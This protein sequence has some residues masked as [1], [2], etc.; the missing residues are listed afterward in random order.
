MK[1]RSILVIL[2]NKICYKIILIMYFA[3]WSNLMF[4]FVFVFFLVLVGGGGGGGQFKVFFHMF[5][6]IP[7]RF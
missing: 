2:K 3:C 5:Y 1:Q 6:N 7:Y 4:L